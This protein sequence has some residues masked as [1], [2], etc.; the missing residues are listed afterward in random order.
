MV[1]WL[2]CIAGELLSLLPAT[3]P[4]R[5][6]DKLAIEDEELRTWRR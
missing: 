3:R 6:R 1:A 5:W 4:R 2:C